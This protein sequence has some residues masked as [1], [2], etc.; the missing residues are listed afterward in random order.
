MYIICEPVM[1]L[2]INSNFTV[3]VTHHVDLNA[4]LFYCFIVVLFFVRPKRSMVWRTH[5]TVYQTL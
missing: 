1:V 4:H 3:I 5:I 2:Y